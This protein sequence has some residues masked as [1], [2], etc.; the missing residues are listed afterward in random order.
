MIGTFITV[1]PPS[2]MMS[3]LK[4]LLAWK[5]DVHHVDPAGTARMLC[6]TRAEVHAKGRPSTFPAIAGHRAGELHRLSG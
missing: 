4:R 3:A 2:A 1:K 5:L 6:R